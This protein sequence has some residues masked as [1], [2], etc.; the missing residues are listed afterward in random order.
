MK[1]FLS[2]DFQMNTRLDTHNLLHG[3]LSPEQIQAVHDATIEVLSKTGF[4]F[5]CESVRNVFKNNGFRVED[6]KVYFT[7]DQL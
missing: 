4:R 6:G 3:P 7:E 2:T 1:D 5:V